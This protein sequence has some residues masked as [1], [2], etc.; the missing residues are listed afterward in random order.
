MDVDGR[1]AEGVTVRLEVADSGIGIAPEK[2]EAVF[3][4]FAQADTSTTRR[5]GG[6]GLGLAISRH[7]ARMLG[8]DIHV[9]STPGEG[10]TFT[11]KLPV[12]AVDPRSAGLLLVSH[13]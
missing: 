1:D 9:R 2:L 12:E 8:G 13:F 3:E 7:Y 6:T 4:S 11:L 5:Y 10:S